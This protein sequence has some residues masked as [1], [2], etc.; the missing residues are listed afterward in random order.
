MAAKTT[1]SSRFDAHFE[2]KIVYL[3]HYT[4]K[5][6][7]TSLLSCLIIRWLQSMK[8]PKSNCHF[9][10][11]NSGKKHV[12]STNF[13]TN[14][15]NIAKLYRR[16]SGSETD[17]WQIDIPISWQNPLF[18]TK[19]DIQIKRTKTGSIVPLYRL[20][21]M[22]IKQLILISRYRLSNVVHFTHWHG[23]DLRQ[24]RCHCIISLKFSR[25]S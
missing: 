22:Y 25:I 13:V 6:Y 17:V 5:Q 16:L 1:S 8:K 11:Q 9:T 21:K 24:V 23:K 18:E 15:R 3:W 12:K 2:Y 4:C 20:L 10:M 7:D 14:H 19:T